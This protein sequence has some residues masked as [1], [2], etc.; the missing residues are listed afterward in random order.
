MQ[1][2]ATIL[3]TPAEITHLLP[4]TNHLMK[5]VNK[6]ATVRQLNS[7]FSTPLTG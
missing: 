5:I 3:N 1:C 7:K 2:R 6:V 4:A